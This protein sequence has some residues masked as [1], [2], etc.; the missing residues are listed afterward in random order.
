MISN[1]ETIGKW[2]GDS[3]DSSLMGFKSNQHTGNNTA[4]IAIAVVGFWILDLSNNT[5]QGPCRYNVSCRNMFSLPT[6]ALLVD[7]APLSQ[8][9]L[10]GSFFSFMLGMHTLK[11]K[12]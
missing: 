8:Q 4:A 6:R 3:S 5:V 9:N 10:G 2:L 7:V 1:A 12:R 11:I